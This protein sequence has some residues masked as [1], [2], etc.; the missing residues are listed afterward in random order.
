ML[1]T[2]PTA[3]QRGLAVAP[4]IGEQPFKPRPHRPE[5]PRLVKALGRTRPAAALALLEYARLTSQP[6]GAN[7]N[8]DLVQSDGFGLDYRHRRRDDDDAMVSD[9]CR[10]RVVT[11]KRWADPATPAREVIFRHSPFTDPANPFDAK[12]SGSI[13]RMGSMVF[14]T[15]MAE[16]DRPADGLL[17]E[18]GR[19]KGGEPIVPRIEVDGSRGAAQPQRSKEDVARYLALPVDDRDRDGWRRVACNENTRAGAASNPRRDALA[20]LG[21]D[22]SVG[23]AEARRRAGLPPG[24]RHSTGI[25]GAGGFLGGVVHPRPSSRSAESHGSFFDDPR[26]SLSQPDVDVLDEALAGGTYEDVG[27]VAGVRTSYA[28]R[29]GKIVFGKVTDRLLDVMPD[30]NSGGGR[31]TA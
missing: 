27:R 17:I 15:A 30:N 16:I 23:F 24:E 8:I 7:D 20:R 13:V 21:L 11:E 29:A 28:G 26:R 1:T 31:L 9:A 3:G 19:S 2:S 22:G 18:F 14:D 10:A 12:V 6:E 4:L 25:G 5:L